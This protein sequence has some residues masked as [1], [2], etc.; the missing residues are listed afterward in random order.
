MSARAAV[1]VVV[2]VGLVL[3]LGGCH[4]LLNPVDPTSEVYEG[5]VVERNDDETNG[6]DT[7]DPLPTVVR[8][9]SY[10]SHAPNLY[11]PLQITADPFFVE[12]RVAGGGPTGTTDLV[13]AITFEQEIDASYIDDTLV[14]AAAGYEDA[15]TGDPRSMTPPVSVEQSDSPKTL[16]IWLYSVPAVSRCR[17]RLR[18]P[19]G[20]TV[21]ERFFGVLGGDVDGSGAVDASDTGAVSDPA[22]FDQFIDL[23]D[24]ASIRADILPT[25]VIDADDVNVVADF[26]GYAVPEE[27]PDFIGAN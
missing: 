14:D 10:R 11:V 8:W 1:V 26:S 21:D 6:G 27:N 9:E 20:R 16:V 22:Y 2:V 5:V 18:A 23:D 19:D 24:Q 4:R 15:D 13:L 7:V 17:V 3:C 25:G 12:P